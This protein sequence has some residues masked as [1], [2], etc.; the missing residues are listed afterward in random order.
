MLQESLGTGADLVFSSG[1]KLLGGPQAGLIVGRRDLIE[2]LKR[3]PIARAARLDK[4]AIAALATTLGH[5]VKN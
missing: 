1:D 2:T 4:G 5:Y 3:H